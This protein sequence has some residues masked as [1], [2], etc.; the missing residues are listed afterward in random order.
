MDAARDVIHGEGQRL[1][2]WPFQNENM[3]P[4]LFSH[5]I[6]ALLWGVTIL[7]L[8][9]F[10]KVAARAQ[11]N[12]PTSPVTQ[13]G[14]SMVK[15]ATVYSIR[16][17]GG[18]ASSFFNFLRTN[19]FANDTILFSGRAG[20]IQVPN[21]TVNN[22][23][24]KDVAKAIELV[25]EDRLKVEVEESGAQSD[26]N[27]WR[28]KLL[29]SVAPIKTR[30]CAMPNLFRRGRAKAIERV[31]RI[32]QAVQ[33]ALESEVVERNVGLI[34]TRGNIH[35]LESEKIVVVVGSEAYVEAVAS[36]LEAAE[37]V[38]TTELVDKP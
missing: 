35:P 19:G 25:T 33:N 23:R 38:A 31:S 13:S 1:Q 8:A 15:G 6:R 29:E 21:F 14:S 3:K 11:T 9:L 27:V 7:S 32:A 16:F 18:T 24:L 20:D 28:I 17:P 2:S 4:K 37:K 22:V 10:G 12:T 30:A 34:I 5:N 36:A 26:V